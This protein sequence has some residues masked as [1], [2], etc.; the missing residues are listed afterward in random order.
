LFRLI[1]ERPAKTFEFAFTFAHASGSPFFPSADWAGN[2]FAIGL[3]ATDLATGCATPE[4]WFERLAAAWHELDALLADEPG[5]LGID[6]SIAPLFADAGSLIG[7]VRRWC[8]SFDRAATSDLF[9]RITACV[10]D[11][12]PRPVGLNGLM[13]PCLEDFLLAE[14]YAAG[15][16]GIERNLFLSLHCGLGI[17]TY[18][19]GIDESPARVLEV[20]R[21][22][23]GLAQRYAKPLSA[24]FVSDGRARIGETTRFG[25]PH[26]CDVAVRPL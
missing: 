8:G 19:L 23:H 1:R 26:L 12:N 4:A 13:L 6:A 20:L 18:P 2:G 25:N 17:D 16:F 7:H 5:Y 22:L 3:Q 11:A 21:L 14:E 10:R 9:L 15:R 24:R